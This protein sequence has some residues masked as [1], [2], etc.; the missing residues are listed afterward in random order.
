L[1][2]LDTV[3]D[4]VPVGAVVVFETVHVGEP[5]PVPVTVYVDATPSAV[6]VTNALSVAPEE[7]PPRLLT[8]GAVKV[9][10]A[11][12]AAEAADT[13]DV[14]PLPEGVTVKVY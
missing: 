7:P 10:F 11:T 2:K 6:N 4:C 14:V 5:V 1:V 8:V 9:N 12:N 13:V 3:Q